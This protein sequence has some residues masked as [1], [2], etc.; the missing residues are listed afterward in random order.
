MATLSSM[1]NIGNELE[2]KLRSIDI[3]T[4]EDLVKVGSKKAFA[5]L[6]AVYPQVCLVHLHALQ[7][8]ID[9]VEYNQLSEELRVELKKFSD[10]LNWH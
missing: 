9:E 2:K 5:H 1:R 10:G 4:A 3:Y 7:G 8:A 6:K